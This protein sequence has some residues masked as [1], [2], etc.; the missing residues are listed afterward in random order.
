MEIAADRGWDRVPISSIPQRTIDAT[1]DTY[2]KLSSSISSSSSSSPSDVPKSKPDQPSPSLADRA[3]KASRAIITKVERNP[4]APDFSSVGKQVEAKAFQFSEGV[5]E[6]AKEVEAALRGVPKS[7]PIGS[8]TKSKTP[9]PDAAPKRDVEAPAPPEYEK[10]WTPPKGKQLYTGPPLPIGFEPPPGYVLPPPKKEPKEPA[11]KEDVLP[12]L[13]PKLNASEPVIAQ[14]AKTIDSLAAFVQANPSA[15]SNAQGVLSTAQIDLEKLGERLESAKAEERKKL[16]KKLDEQAKEYENKLL[17]IEMESK[18]RLDK[19]EED[20]KG[21]F[22]EE[23]RKVVAA[24]RQ[25]LEKELET[26]GEIINQR[27]K[28]EVIAQGI[29]LQRRWIREIKVR[30][31]AER[32]GR[33]AKLDSLSTSLK[34]LERTT[35]D[36]ASY[37]D[38]NIRIHGLLSALRATVRQALESN[39]RR[40]FRDELR[41]LRTVAG[42]SEGGEIL[43]GLLKSQVPDEGVEPRA[44]LSEWFTTSVAP[45]V[46]KAALVP[47]TSAGVLSHL[48]SSIFSSL[49]SAPAPSLTNANDVLSRLA[50]AEYYL[51][52]KDLDSAT[53]EVNQ[54]EGW[55]RR[56]VKD[57][58]EAARKRLEVE[59]ALDVVQTGATLASLL[60]L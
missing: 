41:V 5:S 6:L 19:Q 39:E 28:E 40:G 3:R 32:A 11:K 55:P 43:D 53:R 30:V 17:G 50:R 38:Q 27:L 4:N 7:G 54:L 1:K 37:L 16:E 22:E 20:W 23:R 8:K 46:R 33:L 13:A 47:D 31:E 29:E 49:R 51:G 21:V 35:A 44:D 60:V 48:A 2:N 42:E 34:K 10:E 59:Q 52:I 58:L 9:Y 24:Y 12:L 57:W 15:L 18:E 45:A 25:K 56:L 14:L 36:N 26:Q